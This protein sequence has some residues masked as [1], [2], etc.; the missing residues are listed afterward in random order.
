M[1]QAK[2]IVVLV[3]VGILYSVRRSTQGVRH[4]E[5]EQRYLLEENMVKECINKYIWKYLVKNIYFK[6]VCLKVFS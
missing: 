3:L 2:K 6:S 4:R 5:Y 1:K